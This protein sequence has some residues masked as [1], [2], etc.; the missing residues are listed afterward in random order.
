MGIR[1]S[2]SRSQV[3][4]CV[5]QSRKPVRATTSLNEIRKVAADRRHRSVRA[6]EVEA[7]DAVTRRSWLTL[8]TQTDH[9]VRPDGVG[10]RRPLGVGGA[11]IHRPDRKA[12]IPIAVIRPSSR[13]ARSHRMSASL[14]GPCGPADDE[15]VIGAATTRIDDDPLYRRAAD[16]RPERA[17]LPGWRAASPGDAGP[18]KIQRPQRL[19]PADAVRRQPVPRQDIR[20]LWVCRAEI[21]V[22]QRGVNRGP[23]AGTGGPRRRRT[24]GS[25]LVGQRAGA[26]PVDASFSAAG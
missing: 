2:R 14:T 19:R 7:G 12:S 22:H 13:L 3:R 9:Q 5:R 17:P 4:P 11:V 6:A 18:E 25:E 20:A 16:R 26:Q 10:G 15:A 8:E 23:G 1:V 21:S 24:S